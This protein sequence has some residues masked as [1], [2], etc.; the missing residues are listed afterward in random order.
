MWDDA[1]C[2]GVWST[3]SGTDTKCGSTK[4]ANAQISSTA[5]CC[6]RDC[7]LHCRRLVGGLG[8]TGFRMLSKRMQMHSSWR[9]RPMFGTRRLDML[10]PSKNSFSSL[11]HRDEFAISSLLLFVACE[12]PLIV[13]CRRS[14][15]EMH[16]GLKRHCQPRLQNRKRAMLLQHCCDMAKRVVGM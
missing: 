8:P 12:L 7:K 3:I 6:H 10:L 2:S 11:N 1:V 15:S 16:V 13:L 4:Q 14:S 9:A 5:A